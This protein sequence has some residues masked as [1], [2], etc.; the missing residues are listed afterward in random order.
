MTR[1]I[2]IT[3][4]VLATVSAIA[5]AAYFV[6]FPRNSFIIFPKPGGG[7]I[8][9]SRTSISI[10]A[11]PDHYLTNGFEHIGPYISR[12]LTPSHGFKSLGISTPDGQ[13][14][15]L[16]TA[17]G[18]KVEAF[19]SVE[20]RQKPEQEAA[21]RKLFKSLGVTPTED[22][23]ASNGGVPDSTRC[24]MYPIS[25]NADEVTALTKRILQ[26]LCGIIPTEAVD[27]EYQEK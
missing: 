18:G 15:L 25:G 6:F 10:D 5:I 3:F 9:F 19:F 22:Y 16:F 27:I 26:D 20:W 7:S 1:I 2:T 14:A 23:L 11:P 12:F 4:L 17:R 8:T 13:H 21:I 24:L